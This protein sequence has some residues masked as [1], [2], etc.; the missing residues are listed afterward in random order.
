MSKVPGRKAQIRI[1]LQRTEDIASHYSYHSEG[2]M[3]FDVVIPD[4]VS[5]GGAIDRINEEV[6]KF[7][8]MLLGNSK[9]NLE[10]LLPSTTD[11][12]SQLVEAEGP[13]RDE[14]TDE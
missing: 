8:H 9:R 13:E 6:A 3:T 5:R 14:D 2:S 4:G 1:D 12:S 7:L 10:A 11:V